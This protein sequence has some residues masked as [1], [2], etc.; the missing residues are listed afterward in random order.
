M[1]KNFFVAFFFIALSI[2]LFS[3]VV[4]I[5]FGTER[6]R[7][8]QVWQAL[9][10]SENAEPHV[11][12]IVKDIRLPRVVLAGL[13]GALL[14]GSGAVFQGFFRNP[15]ADSGIMGISSGATLGAVLSAMIPLGLTCT[16]AFVQANLTALCAFAGAIATALIVYAVSIFHGQRG[17]TTAIILTGT[18]VSSFSSA[19]TSFLILVKDKELYRMFN[20]TLGSF[21]G[22][23]WEDLFLLLP[24]TGIATLLLFVCSGFLDILSGGQQTAQALGLNLTTARR[25]VLASGSLAAATGV[26]MGGTIGFVGLVAPH[27]IRRIFS[28]KHRL[29]VPASMIC[30]GTFLVLADTIARSVAPPSELPV[31][32]ITA[33]V[34]AP[35]F[36]CLLFSSKGDNHA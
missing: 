6:I 28:P 36:V 25:L 5:C 11:A 31:G 22:K 9:F 35:F 27:I 4:G 15:L 26:C 21:N 18:A 20:W 16:S 12:I 24:A 1:K 33:L 29:L 30:G 23:G 8:A 2:F 34:G 3:M 10:F 19:V 7:F 32:I 13:C 14:A 17:D